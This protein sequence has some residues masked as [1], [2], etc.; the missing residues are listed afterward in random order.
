MAITVTDNRTAVDRFDVATNLSSP[1]AGETLNQFTTDPDPKELT[2]HYGIAVSTEESEILATISSVDLSSGVLVYGWSL[3]LGTMDT[4]ANLGI[5]MVLGDGTNTNAYEVAGGA[6]AVF[7]HS[8]GQP[9][10]QCMLLDTG[11]LPAGGSKALRGTF[12]SIS[13]SA[14]TEFGA[15]YNTLS[16]A[17]GGA[18]NCFTDQ[19][20]YGNGGLTITGTETATLLDDLAA[21]D[22]GNVSDEAYGICRDLEGGI[23]GVQGQLLFG[24]TGSGTD[25]LSIINQTLKFEDFSGVG[26]DKFGLTWQGGSGT[27]TFVVDNSTLFCPTTT[28]AF[29]T[30]SDTDI[31]SLDITNSNILNFTLGDTDIV[32]CTDATNGPNHDISNNKFIGC[33]QINPGKTAFQDNTIDST[34]DA[35]GGMIIDSVVSMTNISGLVFISDGTGHAIYITATG[36]YTFTNFSYSG[37]G[38]DDTTDAVVYN[39]SGGLV[40]INLSGG[41]TP[42]VRNGASASTTVNVSRTLTI[43]GLTTSTEVRIID[44]SDNSELDGVENS[45][46][47]F[48]YVYTFAPATTIHI[49]ILHIDKEYERFAYLLTDSDE[50]FPTQQRVDR[51]YSNPA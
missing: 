35:N 50:N 45:G 40:T 16:K 29:I 3:A 15:N 34:T 28:G 48:A 22:A 14:L 8:A 49:V 10:Y 11:A 6:L 17:L 27:Q 23:F 21:K 26:N 37:Y 36:T 24:D 12:G 38:A 1:V 30:A 51:V 7:R 2:A 5:S 20:F 25:T 43:T 41:G 42:T 32:F 47:T 4:V 39:N 44:P 31:E 46:T 33:A 9:S 18:S 13:L 19:F